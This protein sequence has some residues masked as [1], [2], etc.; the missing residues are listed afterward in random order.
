VCSRASI[1]SKLLA[2]AAVPAA[3]AVLAVRAAAEDRFAGVEIRAQHVAGSVHMLQG[4]GG[5]IGVSVGPDGILIVDD[6][7]APL[8][9]KIRAALRGLG[10]GKLR[11]VLNTHWHGDHTGGNVAFGPEA[12]ILAHDNVRRR[13]AT[14][15]EVMGRVVDPLPKEALPVITFSDRLTVHFN[16]EEIRMIHFPRGHTDGDSVIWFTGSNVV[17]MGDDF[18][19]GKFPFVDLDSGGDVEGLIR[20]VEQ[21]IAQLPPNVRIV[22]GHGPLSSAENLR[23]YHDMLL[24]T[25]AVVRGR[26]A[27]GKSLGE[28]QREGLPEEWRDWG[29]GFISTERWLEIVHR[30][31]SARP[32]G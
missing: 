17:H 8:A 20:N 26:M 3:L 12:P 22:P 15:Q 25:T 23:R 4:S 10:E 28:I 24:R 21:V 16:G 2:G 30:S 13:L 1:N 6:Q 18:F 11:F 19:A 5:N 27:A 14:R 31:L 29:S 7:F 9:D 32:G